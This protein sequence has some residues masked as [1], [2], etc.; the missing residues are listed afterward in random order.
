M[1]RVHHFGVFILVL[2]VGAWL[3]GGLGR[4]AGEP[5]GVIKVTAAD[6]ASGKVVVVGKLGMPLNT[7]TTIRGTW[8]RSRSYK[9]AG[10]WLH[11][12]HVDGKALGK[13]VEFHRALVKVAFDDDDAA[14]VKPSDGETWEIQGYETGKFRSNQ[15][16]TRQAPIWADGHF[17][18]ELVGTISRP[19]KSTKKADQGKPRRSEKDSR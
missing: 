5:E 16:A 7:M 10:P 15:D 19:N 1:S 9:D 4:A 3:H 8:Q 6:L 17:L 11:V 12:T 13:P 14:S 18:S 2:S